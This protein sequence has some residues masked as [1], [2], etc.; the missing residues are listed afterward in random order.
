[1]YVL[2]R[3]GALYYSETNADVKVT[4]AQSRAPPKKDCFC[5][6]SS[7]SVKLGEAEVWSST[8]VLLEWEIPRPKSSRP[9]TNPIFGVI[10]KI[11]V[12]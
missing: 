9:S 10:F 6:G 11:S 5:G 4:R 12:D 3:W 2:F 1:M 8:A 7:E